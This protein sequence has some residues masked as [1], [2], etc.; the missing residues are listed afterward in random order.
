MKRTHSR[1]VR[2]VGGRRETHRKTLTHS[3]LRLVDAARRVN[4][5][6]LSD[7]DNDETN[8]IFLDT[9]TVNPTRR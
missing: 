4:R 1:G 7:R 6:S 5:E 2:G 8:P 9:R 3:G